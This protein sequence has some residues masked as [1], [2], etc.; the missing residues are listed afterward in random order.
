MKKLCENLFYVCFTVIM[1]GVLAW[2]ITSCST[3]PKV[4]NKTIWFVLM[5]SQ[6]PVNHI[7]RLGFEDACKDLKLDCRVNTYE[8][9]DPARYVQAIEETTAQGGYG[10]VTLIGLQSQWGV[11]DQMT[12]SGMK[13]IS[14]HVPFTGADKPN[15]L[16]WVS[17][18]PLDY[19]RRAAE[20]MGAKLGGKG[21]VAVTLGSINDTESPVAEEFTKYMNNKYPGITVLAPEEEGFDEL[22]AI[23]KA[24]SIIQ[25]HPDLAGA[26]STTGG[27]ATT[28]SKAAEETGHKPG[29]ITI[30]SMD[31]TQPNLDL[32]KQ[33]WVYKLVGQ[34]LYEEC[35]LAVQLLYLKMNGGYVDFNNWLPAPM[36]GLDNVDQFYSINT[37]A[38]QF[39]L[40][41][42]VPTP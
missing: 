33:G 7:M 34:P 28:W 41:T 19:A 35:R 5:N 8:M 23:T 18:D 36:V 31:Y 24:S 20:E 9:A 14:V 21:V 3:T 30:I 6:H 32:L 40:P 26:F 37:R 27:G 29:D 1:L 10:V 25:A 39:N 15:I 12:K 22:Q 4:T 13:V 38:A 2:A 17:T 42:P 11:I 16:A